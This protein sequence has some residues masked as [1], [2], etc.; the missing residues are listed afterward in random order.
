MNGIACMQ[1]TKIFKTCGGQGERGDEARLAVPAGQLLVEGQHLL[2]AGQRQGARLSEGSSTRHCAVFCAVGQSAMG[3]GT[4]SAA[5]Q[6]HTLEALPAHPVAAPP[7]LPLLRWCTGSASVVVAGLWRGRDFARAESSW[8]WSWRL[9]FR[10]IRIRFH[11]KM[12]RPLGR[13]VPYQLSDG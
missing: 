3:S 7:Q 6:T 12:C 4:R 8:S 11:R 10:S 2:D 5:P 1:T 9:L 13:P